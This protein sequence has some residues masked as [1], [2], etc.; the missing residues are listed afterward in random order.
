MLKY[1]PIIL[2]SPVFVK[3][4]EIREENATLRKRCIYEGISSTLLHEK[5]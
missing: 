1:I 4:T 5:T 3:A 2:Q